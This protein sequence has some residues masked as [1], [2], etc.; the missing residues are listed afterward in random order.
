MFFIIKSNYVIFTPWSEAAILNYSQS[1]FQIQP[2][3]NLD[4]QKLKLEHFLLF[5]A[6]AKTF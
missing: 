1:L 6:P 4:N 3:G 5:H 2:L